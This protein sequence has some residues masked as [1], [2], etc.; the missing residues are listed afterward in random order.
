MDAVGGDT[1]AGQ[2]DGDH[3]QHQKGHNDLHG[4]GDKG[5]HLAHLH[6]T[7]IHR[8]AAKPDDQ[9]AGAV[10]DQGHKGHHGNHGT[11]GEQLGFHQIGVCLVKAL[12]L[13]SLATEGADGHNAG[14]NLA[15]DKVQTVNKGLHLLELGHCHAHQKGNQ[16]QQG[17]HRHKDDPLQTGAALGNMQDA[18]DA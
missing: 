5:N 18:A 9:Q 16:Q 2:H 13:K 8:L 14:Q 17:S 4:V 1:C 6:R 11:V 12:F 3:R 15:A 10:H 7:Q